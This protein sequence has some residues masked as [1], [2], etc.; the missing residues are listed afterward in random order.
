MSVATPA[1]IK[2]SPTARESLRGEEFRAALEEA[3]TAAEA[4]DRIGPLIAATKLRITFRFTDVGLTLNVAA[5]DP[6]DRNL[7]W[8][9]GEN[10]EPSKLELTMDSATAN[11]FLQGRESLAIAI[12][13]GH[14]KVRGGSRNA[15]L[16]LP[17]T[18]LLCQSYRE[19]VTTEHPA[20]AAD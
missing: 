12:A 1:G 9:W 10:S 2:Q 6:Q 3:L 4:D 18:R 20:L 13:R 11:R 17:A 8:S 15:L 7:S 14:A 16:G 5:G 19:V